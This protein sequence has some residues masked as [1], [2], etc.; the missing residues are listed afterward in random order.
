MMMQALQGGLGNMFGCACQPVA[1]A[2]A[3]ADEAPAQA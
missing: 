3:P 2:P 1:P